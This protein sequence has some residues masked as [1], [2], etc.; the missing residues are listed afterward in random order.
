MVIGTGRVVNPLA[1]VRERAW[2]SDE[3]RRNR[4]IVVGEEC[5]E[6][7]GSG[8]PVD[9]EPIGAVGVANKLDAHTV[10]VAPEAGRRGGGR[11][12]AEH[13]PRCAGALARCCLPVLGADIG[14]AASIELGACIPRREDAGNRRASR[15][16]NAHAPLI[17]PAV[18]QPRGRRFGSDPDDEQVAPDPA[19]VLELDGVHGPSAVKACDPRGEHELDPFPAVKVSEPLAELR[20]EDRLQGVPAASMIVTVAPSRFAVAAT[21]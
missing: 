12:Q 7:S 3:Q 14:I 20:S 21:S 19:P 15:G 16:V 6:V 17:E 18:A 10:L 11:L 1:K 4:P 8:L 13:R 5:G 9:L 2:A